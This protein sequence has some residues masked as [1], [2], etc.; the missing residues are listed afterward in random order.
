MSLGV[1][2]QNYQNLQSKVQI[3]QNNNIIRF[4]VKVICLKSHIY[5]YVYV[6]IQDQLIYRRIYT[7]LY[8]AS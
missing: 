2:F 4:N 5:I 1:V 7:F 3:Y 6:Y 8:M